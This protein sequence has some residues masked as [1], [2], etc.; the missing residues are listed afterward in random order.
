MSI[1]KLLTIDDMDKKKIMVVASSA[2]RRAGGSFQITINFLLRTLSDERIDWL[3]VVSQD[4]DDAIGDKFSS[5]KGKSYFVVPPQPTVRG[6][7][8]V[9]NL[10]AHLEKT[11]NPNL[12]YSVISPSYFR[13]KT[14]EI[15]RHTDPYTFNSSDLAYKTWTWK[16]RLFQKIKEIGVRRMLRNAY[17]FETQSQAVADET[18]KATGKHVEVISNILPATY[19]KVDVQSQKVSHENINIVYVTAGQPHKCLYMVPQVMSLLVHKY[20]KKNIHFIYT[21]PFGTPH[22]I[23]LEKLAEQNGVKDYIENA[24]YLKQE[25]L[26]DLYLRSDIGFFASLLETFSATLLEYMYFRIPMVVTDL[27]FNTEVTKDAALYFQPNNAEDAAA[28]L[29]EIIEKPELRDN[30]LAHADNRMKCFINYEE[31]YNHK[32]DF[33]MR[34]AK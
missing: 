16:S 13:F 9:K 17:A 32:I 33:L 21:I 26:I 5:L 14:R 1:A 31:H 3:Y 4:V 29:N 25:Q 19:L 23:Y 34:C 11:F 6:Y 18:V 15:M 28:K 24:G 20:N 10:M 12:I 2:K 22:A 30:L 7:M 8:T 27:P